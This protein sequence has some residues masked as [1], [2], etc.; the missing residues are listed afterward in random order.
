[1]ET[2][3][4]YD[5]ETS[6]KACIYSAALRQGDFIV[7][8]L[9]VAYCLSIPLLLNGHLQSPKQNLK[10]IND[11]LQDFCNIRKYAEVEFGSLFEKCSEEN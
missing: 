2:S 11:I 7:A 6:T 10:N 8:L 4:N 1:M 5:S 9:S 3:T